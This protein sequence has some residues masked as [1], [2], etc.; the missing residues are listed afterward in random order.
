MLVTSK[1]TI[2]LT[3]KAFKQY[4]Y[5]TQ[6]D[7]NTRAVEITLLANGE[8]WRVPEG[9]IG[10]V[11]FSKP[12]K[13]S[14]L[15]DTLPDGATKAVTCKDNRVIA[16]FAPQVLAISG[17]VDV[18]VA[19]FD[20]A[21]NRLGTFPFTIRVEKNPSSGQDISNDYYSF[22]T[23]ENITQSIGD[24]N[25]LKTANKTNLVDAINEVAASGSGGS[26][27]GTD[28]ILPVATPNRL[29]GVKPV[30]KTDDMTEPV[31]VDEN[32]GLWGKAGGEEIVE[33]VN[34]ISEE[35]VT[36]IS[37]QFTNADIRYK[38]YVM[39]IC[40][41]GTSENAKDVDVLINIDYLG[42]AWVRNACRNVDGRR[43]FVSGRIY[44]TPYSHGILD[45]IFTHDNNRITTL[46]IPYIAY[47]TFYGGANDG[48]PS[49]IVVQPQNQLGTMAAGTFIKVW[50]VK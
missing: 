26:S 30:A 14:G 9:T 2:D 17:E 31:G 5:A 11:S 18:S 19:L 13:T 4:L 33:L 6:D 24:L 22:K 15:Y 23:L 32:G 20:S 34:F 12:D 16:I 44:A 43:N 1:I 38:E 28:Y 45:S 10:A 3:R 41:I 48:I 40:V 7:S 27:G 39:D 47:T 46:T 35:D 36:T 29:G 49:K 50:G 21:L 8:A 37:L 25:D 42:K